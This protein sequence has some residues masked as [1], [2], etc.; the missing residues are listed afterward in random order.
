MSSGFSS[1]WKFWKLFVIEN[2][3][4]KIGLKNN[5]TGKHLKTCYTSIKIVM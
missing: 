5:V 1:L 2:S 3:E 4:L